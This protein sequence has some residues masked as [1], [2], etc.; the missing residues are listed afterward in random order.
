MTTT[1]PSTTATA[2]TT[3]ANSL[4]VTLQSSD[5]EFLRYPASGKLTIMESF[6]D[7]S[8]SAVFQ[9]GE[10]DNCKFIPTGG[11]VI[12]KKPVFNFA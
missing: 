10:Y 6:L 11:P 5:N 7:G 12:V 1:N 4:R 2:P 8:I 9:L 3:A